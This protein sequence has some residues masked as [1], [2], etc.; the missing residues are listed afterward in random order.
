VQVA[1][2]VAGI[3]VGTLAFS[4]LGFVLA[5]TI[6]GV[7]STKSCKMHGVRACANKTLVVRGQVDGS[8]RVYQ[9]FFYAEELRNEH[10]T[11]FVH[12]FAPGYVHAEA[13]PAQ[14]AFAEDDGAMSMTKSI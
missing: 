11:V 2:R 10:N 4:T 7:T 12:E 13:I 5:G 14:F 1:A 6:S 3:V 8:G 9:L